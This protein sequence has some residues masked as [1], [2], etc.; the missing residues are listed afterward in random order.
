MAV[1][2]NGERCDGCRS[3][4]EPPCQ[5]VC[6]GGLLCTDGKGKATIREPRDCWDCAAC[7][8]ECPREAIEMYLPVEAGGRGSSLS[9]RKQRGGVCWTLMDRKGKTKAIFTVGGK[10]L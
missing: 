5:R 9:A 8:K 10:V 7:V 3:A 6:P 2:I 4:K 1:R